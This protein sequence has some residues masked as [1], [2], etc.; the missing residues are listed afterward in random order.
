MQQLVRGYWILILVLLFGFLSIYTSYPSY[1]AP[2]A[3]STPDVNTVPKPV[4]TPTPENTPFPTPTTVSDNSGDDESDDNQGAT[5]PEDENQGGD[6]SAGDSNSNEPATGAGSGNASTD[7]AAATT[8]NAQQPPNG[9]TG[10]V[11]AVTLN[12]RKGPGA[13]TNVIDTLF[14]NDPV[15]ILARN[16]TGDWL[17]ICCGSRTKFA[18]WVSKQFVSVNNQAMAQIPLFASTANQAS[19]TAPIANTSNKPAAGTLVLEM[20]PLASSVWQG[21]NVAIQFVI[22]NRSN[23]AFTGIQLRNDLP[24][25]MAVVNAQISNQGKV[26]YSGVRQS[27]PVMT[28]NWPTVQANSQVTATVMVQIATNVADG[29]LIDSLAVVKTSQGGEALAGITLAMPPVA[30]PQFREP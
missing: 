26:S 12:L 30:L 22:R 23:Q 29:A 15:A 6:T 3:Q 14:L 5:P 18:G 1:G 24:D 2:A 10:V 28:I 9:V 27:G 4:K 17:Y 16:Q 21:Q 7:N 20:R 25:E 19:A 8:D 13:T 11:T